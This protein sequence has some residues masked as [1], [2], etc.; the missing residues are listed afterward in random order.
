MSGLTPRP[1]VYRPSCLVKLNARF[2]TAYLPATDPP[3]TTS[4]QQPRAEVQ[5][6]GNTTALTGA[7]NDGLTEQIVVRPISASVEVPSPREAGRFSLEFLYR[8]FPVDPRM[9]SAIACE[10]YLGGVSADK[11][12]Q[13]IGGQG[14]GLGNS[15]ALVSLTDE[16]L[17]VV[18]IVDE[19]RVRHDGQMSRV[20]LEGRDLR[21]VLLDSPAPAALFTQ[22]DLRKPIQNVVRQILDKHPFGSTLSLWYFPDEWKVPGEGFFGFPPSPY[23]SDGSTRVRLGATGKESKGTPKTGEEVSFWDLITNYC[24]LCGVLPYFSG[25]KLLLRRARSYW[26]QLGTVRG[27]IY[28]RDVLSLEINRR[29]QGSNGLKGRAVMVTSIDTDSTQRGNARL[30]EV[31]WGPTILDANN[32]DNRGT[33]KTGKIVKT[34]EAALPPGQTTRPQVGQ[35]SPSGLVGYT[36]VIRIPVSGI[37]S[38]TQLLEVAK[39]VYEEIGRGEMSGAFETCNL[40]TYGRPDLEADLLK[41]RPGDAVR[42]QVDERLS[43]GQAPAVSPLQKDATSAGAERIRE[44]TSRGI[45]ARMAAAIVQSAERGVPALAP[46]FRAKHVKFDYSVTTGVKITCDFE[47]YVEATRAKTGLAVTTSLPTTNTTGNVPTQLQAVEVP[48]AR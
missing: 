39:A 17:V 23:S 36:D 16:N 46:V 42:I 29:F 11:S 12:A 19:V 25:N 37:K 28:G 2:D 3:G 15:P 33:T 24:F 6:A 14:Y 18:G 47:N 1:P 30:K 31:V 40:A 7:K 26:S 44:M 21:G 9:F 38:E 32:P 10:V 41:L 20:T 27:I 8:D 45:P 48:S 13:G 22:L 43:T 35:I 34:H 4:L 5:Q